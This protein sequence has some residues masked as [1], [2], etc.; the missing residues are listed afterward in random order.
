MKRNLIFAVGALL[1]GIVTGIFVYGSGFFYPKHYIQDETG[2]YINVSA[3]A[4][5]TFPVN[6]YTSFVIEYYYP[7][8]D[9]LLTETLS[10]YPALLG[11]D[12]K[13][14]QNYLLD[15]MRHLSYKDRE[16]G[17][18]AFELVSYKDNQICLRKTFCKQQVKGYVAKSYNGLIVIM[19]GDGRTVYEYT[20]IDISSLPEDLQERVFVGYPLENEE[21]LYNFLENYSS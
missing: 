8:E 4:P 3:K 21:D 12:K 1:I 15:Y 19:N 13:G 16:D 10:D 2:E 6:E 20:D 5:E 17:L 9:R 14:V 18:Q 11:C 7:E